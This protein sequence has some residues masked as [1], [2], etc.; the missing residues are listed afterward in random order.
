MRVADVHVAIDEGWSQHS[1]RG[2]NSPGGAHVG[3][4]GRLADMADAAVL[5]DHDR[6]VLEHPPLRVDADRVSR[7]FDLE[8]VPTAFSPHPRA[9]RLDPHLSCCYS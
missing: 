5:T 4:L 2:V 6:C 1:A 7:S 8:A 3:Q 9:V